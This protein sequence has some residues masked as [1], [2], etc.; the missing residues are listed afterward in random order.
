[1]LA[2]TVA[3]AARHGTRVFAGSVVLLGAGYSFID[4]HIF[5]PR[6]V[7]TM[8]AMAA[9]FALWTWA[10]TRDRRTAQAATSSAPPERQA[11]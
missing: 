11:A 3:L 4:S 2:G 6:G 9:G 5:R 8:L 7:L 10:A 1:M